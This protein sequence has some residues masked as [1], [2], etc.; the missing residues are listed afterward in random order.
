MIALCVVLALLILLLLTRVRLIAE[1]GGEGLFLIAAAGLVRIKLYPRPE[2]KPKLKKPQKPE[3]PEPEEDEKPGTFAMIRE[4]LP[5]ISDTFGKLRRKLR[6]DVLTIHFTAAAAD[7]FNAAMMFGL[8]SAGIGVILPILENTFNVRDRDLRTSVS[9]TEDKPLVYIKAKF[10]LA[11]W[12][13]L[14]IASSFIVKYMKYRK[15]GNDNGEASSRRP[16]GNH[17]EQ[18]P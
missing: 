1:Y 15:E 16:D 3:K 2:K 4:L 12:E 13:I 17:N 7:P 18:N 10:S 6:I 8:G 14:Y 9:F 11:I 5:V